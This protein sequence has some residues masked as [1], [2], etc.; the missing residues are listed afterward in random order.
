MSEFV[1]STGI[2]NIALKLKTAQ[3]FTGNVLD[4]LDIDPYT[5]NWDRFIES[6]DDLE[7]DKYMAD[8]GAYRS[9][10]YSEFKI[11]PQSDSFVSLPQMPFKQSLDVNYLN[12]GIDRHY[13]S[14][15]PELVTNPAFRRVLLGC[16]KALSL[17]NS[18]SLWRVQVFQNRIW[19]RAAEEGNPTPEGVHRDGVDYVLTL[20][21]SR[22]LVTGGESSTYLSDRKTKVFSH[23]LE[24][25]GEFIFLDD[26]RMSH[27]VSPVI[28]SQ[29]EGTGYRDVLVAMYSKL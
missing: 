11:D 23:T 9:R 13:L 27:G 21:G 10:R 5:E 8:G 12:G 22:Y 4:D 26:V 15:K 18:H 16:A 17:I 2:A 6:W 1:H 25:S 3:H 19:A 24:Q 28:C 20:L 14:I 29:R 7:D